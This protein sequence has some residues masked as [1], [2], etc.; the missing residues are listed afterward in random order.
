MAERNQVLWPHE[1]PLGRCIHWPKTCAE[2]QAVTATCF[3]PCAHCC[4]AAYTLQ[5][6]AALTEE[7]QCGVCRSPLGP[8]F[9][10]EDGTL[11]PHRLRDGGSCWGAGEKPYARR[12]LTPWTPFEVEEPTD[13]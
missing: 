11:G 12:F 7:W 13:A 8:D 10:E 9:H 4:P 2:V 1:T 3:K 6:P 5:V